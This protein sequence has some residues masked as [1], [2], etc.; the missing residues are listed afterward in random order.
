MIVTTVQK[1]DWV[2]FCV[3][4][5]VNYVESG[6]NVSTGNVNIQCPYCDDPS[7]HLGLSL[8]IARPSWGC[9]RCKAGG[10]SPLRLICKLA[11][12]TLPRALEIVAL[13][14]QPSPDDFERLLDPPGQA[15]KTPRSAALQ[16][17]PE[18]R[19]LDNAQLS[20]E[21]FLQ[22]LANARGFGSDAKSVATEYALHYATSG[23]QAWRI[24]LPIYQ[25]KKLAAWTGRS[26]HWN[27]TVRYRSDFGGRINQCLANTDALLDGTHTDETLVVT[28]GPMDFL[29]LDFYGQRHGL[30]AT[31]T[32]G[33]AW[34]VAQVAKLLPIVKQFRST[35]VL[36]DKNAYMIGAKLA[37]EV[38]AYSHCNVRAVEMHGAKDPGDLTPIDIEALAKDLV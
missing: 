38:A 4:Q 37:E 35:I 31:C 36:Y 32:F 33:T 7:E 14:N 19:C 3:E 13:H 21:R 18:C 34:S 29:K 22:Y 28:E 24:V 5:G 6:A 25:D 23:E 30:R 11:G 27:A 20:A 26:I 15:A 1:F 10:K 9:W 17:P 8:S 2:S 12:V 16:L